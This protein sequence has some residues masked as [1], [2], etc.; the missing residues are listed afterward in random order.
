MKT[1]HIKTCGIVQGVGFRPFVSR[2]ADALGIKG[3]VAN[4]GSYVE[5]FA[6]CS[7]KALNGL[8]SALANDPPERA[9][10]LD[11]ECAECDCPPFEDFQIIEREK[12]SG[13]ILVS[14][15][16]AV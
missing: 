13:E 6:Q 7:E 12:E 1:Y 15:D 14:P 9:V 4:R 11:T 10:I 8:L 5:I 3:T 16:I 2:T